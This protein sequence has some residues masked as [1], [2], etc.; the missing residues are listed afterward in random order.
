MSMGEGLCAGPGTAVTI[1]LTVADAR[2]EVLEDLH[3]QTPLV[4]PFAQ[5]C[6]YPG[7]RGGLAG[8]GPGEETEVF[9][10][11]EHA[12]GR[13]LPEKVIRVR[14]AD[15]PDQGMK[16]GDAYRYKSPDGRERL[17]TITGRVEDRLFLDENHPWA[18]HDLVYRVRVLDVAPLDRFPGLL[19][20]TP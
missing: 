18:G 16:P 1:L 20:E 15:L 8:L 11:M 14:D 3:A 13:R 5:P 4:I 7:L 2:G 10:P 6:A 19:T 17:Y 12:F 9:V